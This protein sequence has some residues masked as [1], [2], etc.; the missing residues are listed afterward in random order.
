VQY[1]QKFWGR[2]DDSVKQHRR[3]RILEPRKKAQDVP[4]VQ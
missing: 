1:F 2:V 4:T 3:L